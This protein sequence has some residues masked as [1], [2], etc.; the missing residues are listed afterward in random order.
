MKIR[1][2]GLYMAR[3]GTALLCVE[4]NWFGRAGDYL[5]HWSKFLEVKRV[6]NGFDEY[7]DLHVGE[8]FSYTEDGLFGGA[9]NMPLYPG[10]IVREI[11]P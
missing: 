7:G 1:K 3:G 9:E 5:A 4:V 11:E 10:H 8:R 2:G 6:G